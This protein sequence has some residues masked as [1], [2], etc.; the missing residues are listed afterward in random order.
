MRFGLNQPILLRKIENRKGQNENQIERL[1]LKLTNN[2]E[3]HS[4][5]EETKDEIKFLV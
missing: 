5:D 1:A 2:I 4:A 3:I